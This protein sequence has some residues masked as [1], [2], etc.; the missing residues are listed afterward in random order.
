VIH[1]L[2]LGISLNIK[3]KMGPLHSQT[4]TNSLSRFP[5]YNVFSILPSVAWVAQVNDSLMVQSN[6]YR[7]D[8]PDVSSTSSTTLMSN[9]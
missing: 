5:E 2:Q 9:M 3:K 4:V 8:G 6:S 1:L 7:V